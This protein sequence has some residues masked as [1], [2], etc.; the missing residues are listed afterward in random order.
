[1]AEV[2][3][4]GISERAGEIFVFAPWIIAKIITRR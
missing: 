3:G 4:S 2:A 1:M